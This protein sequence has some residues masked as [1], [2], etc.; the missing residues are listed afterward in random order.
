MANRTA[1]LLSIALCI[2]FVWSAKCCQDAEA[3]RAKANAES[4]EK[5]RLIEH[6]LDSMFF[7]YMQR[8]KYYQKQK[9]KHD[10]KNGALQRTR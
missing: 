8:E 5:S 7:E 3:G 9:L 10:K 6:K 2:A 4:T 1:S